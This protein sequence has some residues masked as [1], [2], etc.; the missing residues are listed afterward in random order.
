MLNIILRNED[1]LFPYHNIN[2]HILSGNVFKLVLE[3]KYIGI[4]FLQNKR[5]QSCPELRC[6][7]EAQSNLDSIFK[8]LLELKYLGAIFIQKIHKRY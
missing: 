8:I 4:Y 6:K 5:N 1:I 7:H 2:L 3:R